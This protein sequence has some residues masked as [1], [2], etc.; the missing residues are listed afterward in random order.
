MRLSTGAGGGQQACT[1]VTHS[2]NPEAGVQNGFRIRPI[3]RVRTE[4]QARPR[5]LKVT[6]RVFLV[7]IREI[8]RFIV[9]IKT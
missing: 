5:S 9:N 3:L 6:V 8:L 2:N 1:H 4:K 7:G